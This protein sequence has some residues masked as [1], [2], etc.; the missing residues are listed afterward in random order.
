MGLNFIGERFGSRLEHDFRKFKNVKF[1]DSGLMGFMSV[2]YFG[3]TF[4]LG[5][6]RMEIYKK[7]IF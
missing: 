6:E 2:Y 1:K 4:D 7:N 5:G 3:D